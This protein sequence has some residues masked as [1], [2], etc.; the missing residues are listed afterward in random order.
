MRRALCLL[1]LVVTTVLL[2]LVALLVSPFDGKGEQIHRI[3][4][5]WARLYM[6]AA[7]IQVHL[8][9]LEHVSGTPCIFMSNHQSAL[10][11]YTLLAALPYSFKFIAKQELFRIPFF[12]WAIRRA[13]YIS[14]D[15]DHP[16]EALK[17]MDEAARK[18][19]EGTNILMFP[20]GT[21][22]PDGELLPFMKGGFS[23]AMKASVPVVPVAVRGTSLLQ[24]LGSIVPRR[25]GIVSVSLG[26]PVLITSKGSS[27][28][29]DLMD[30]IRSAI[31]GLM[32]C[33]R[34]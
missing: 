27:A 4:R 7:G 31:E 16:R 1:D 19:R 9:G 17:A 3:A 34:N 24:P 21:R 8:R 5:L 23:L 20:E 30:R 22:S 32:T 12:G 25:G 18:I 10:D 26:D 29:T 15:R 33:Q 2:S 11:I 28:R 13:G 14:I 6:R